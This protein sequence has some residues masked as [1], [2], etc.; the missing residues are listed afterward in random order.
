VRRTWG[1][2]NK[3]GVEDPC[4]TGLFGKAREAID[5]F[6]LAELRESGLRLEVEMGINLLRWMLDRF[7]SE[8]GRSGGNIVRN[9]AGWK[10]LKMLMEKKNGNFGMDVID[11]RAVIWDFVTYSFANSTKVRVNPALFSSFNSIF[12]ATVKLR[13]NQHHLS[14]SQRWFVTNQIP[15]SNTSDNFSWS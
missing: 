3:Y 14:T 8:I 5:V 15:L 11:E 4:D 10:E 1:R 7:L 12:N 9:N 2:L 6:K 13:V